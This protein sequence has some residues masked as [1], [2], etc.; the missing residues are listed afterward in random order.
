MSLGSG[1]RRKSP[2]V[3]PAAR[4]DDP[5][6]FAAGVGE[7]VR[8]ARQAMGWTQL[9][10]AENAGF[11]SNYIARLE[12]GELGPSLFVAHQLCGALGIEVEALLHSASPAKTTRRR[13]AG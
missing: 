1:P 5:K 11:S 12:R 7:A 13:I 4:S 10:L 6:L 2:S 9:Q 3:R 8:R